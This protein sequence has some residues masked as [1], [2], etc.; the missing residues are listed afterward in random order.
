VQS[1]ASLAHLDNVSSTGVF[2]WV[3]LRSVIRSRPLGGGRC[4][5]DE[6]ETRNKL[7][8]MV[9]YICLIDA[10]PMNFAPILGLLEH[11]KTKD[12]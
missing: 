3:P 4:E 1:G 5:S 6:C 11:V 9:W 12:T 10:Y 8:Y 2:R 7:Y